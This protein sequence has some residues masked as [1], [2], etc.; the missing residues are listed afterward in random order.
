MSRF[1]FSGYSSTFSGLLISFFCFGVFCLLSWQLLFLPLGLL[2][3]SL[4][5]YLLPQP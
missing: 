5:G 1:T 2:G 3:L 4:H